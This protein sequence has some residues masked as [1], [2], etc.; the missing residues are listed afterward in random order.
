MPFPARSAACLL[1]AIAAAPSTRAAESFDGCRY[2]IT[3]L[4]ATLSSQGVYCL[5][6]DLVA[7]LASGDAILVA[8]NNITIDCNDFKLGNL[9]AGQS[10]T[11]TGIRATARLNTTVRGCTVRGFDSGIVLDGGGHRV[12]DNRVE[13]NYRFGIHVTGAPGIVRD[14]RVNDTGPGFGGD[15]AAAIRVEDGVDVVDNTVH[16]VVTIDDGARGIGIDAELNG[17]AVVRGN[18]I[19]EVLSGDPALPPVGI[20]H[21]Q[22]EADITDNFISVPAG[23]GVGCTFGE[24]ILHGNRFAATGMA[25]SGCDDSG[26]NIVR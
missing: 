18:S 15:R 23:I 12:E 1:I 13:N 17:I 10:T 19:R 22:G 14:N 3:T 11:A 8:A 25:A 21:G 5:R 16:T 7:S 20:L 24:G 4:P 6:Q 2:T 26:G 9:G